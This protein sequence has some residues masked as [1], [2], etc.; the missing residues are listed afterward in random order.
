MFARMPNSRAWKTCIGAMVALIEEAAFKFSPEGVRMRAMDPS[1]VALID[2]EMPARAFDEYE[3]KQ[4]VVLGV[5]L[6]ELNRMLARA[7]PDDEFTM[8]LEEERNRL[9]LTFKGKSTRKLSLPLVD[10]SEGELPEP[11]LEFTATAKLAAEAVQDGLRDAEIV[12]DTVRFEL[13]ESTFKMLAESD[14]GSTELRLR[15]GDPAL[16]KLDIKEPARATFNVKYLGDM[17]K[18]AKPDD[19]VTINLGADLPIN[20]DFPVEEHGRLSFLLAPRIES[21]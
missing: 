9:A 16:A 14:R 12:G 11:K 1:H 19:L 7:R 6:A 17:M 20:L 10:V 5:A 2:F 8:E 13:D 18:A 21:E 15:K 3:V 4:P